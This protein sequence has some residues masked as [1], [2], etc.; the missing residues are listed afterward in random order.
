MRRSSEALG[1]ATWQ[2]LDE[3]AA[4]QL[5][6]KVEDKDKRTMK[7]IREAAVFRG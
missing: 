2:R 7:R 1:A 6:R 4:A 5:E 3:G